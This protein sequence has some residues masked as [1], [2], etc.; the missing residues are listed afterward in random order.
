MASIIAA[1]RVLYDGKETRKIRIALE[2]LICGCLSLAVSNAIEW[3]GWPSSMAVTMGGAIGFVG[4]TAIRELLLKW[5]G[6][7][8]DQ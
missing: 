8:V 5:T 1:L 6:R 7:K 3:L 4:V 2:S